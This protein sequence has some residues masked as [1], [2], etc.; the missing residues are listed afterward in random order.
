MKK[1]LVIQQ[2]MIGDVLA[3]SILCN[4]LRKI[5]PKAQIH[6]MVYPFTKPV[7]ENNPNIDKIITY[8]ES[9]KRNKIKQLRFLW[10]VRKE[11][12]NVV[13]DAYN[14][15]ESFLATL[16]SGADLK[17][18]FY[19]KYTK[20]LYHY[21][22]ELLPQP[23][24]NAGTAIENR[25]NLLEPIAPNFAFDNRPKIFITEA[26][27][28]Q[29]LEN[30]KVHGI[31]ES[32]PYLLISVLGSED[33]KSYPATYMAKTLDFIAEELGYK[34]IF[35]FMPKQ[36]A[37]AR[38]I[39]DLCNPATQALIV[40]NLVAKDIRAFLALTNFS[41]A[42][43]GNEGGAVNMAK[44]L[45]KPTFTIF[46]TW[47]KKEAWSSFDNGITHVSVHLKDFKPELYGEKSPK[48]M[49]DKAMEL[50]QAFSPELL[51]PELQRFLVR[52]K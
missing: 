20:F 52:L 14:K 47:I 26:E 7:I 22:V 21:N 48:E 43:I 19:K 28:Q 38:E 4:N 37:Q 42:L 29:A 25:I 50:Y 34:L 46:S 3:S 35:N 30:L 12:Y 36:Q 39:Y 15:P 31:S 9:L 5:Y 49:K 6:Y 8:D 27:K 23:R 17:I 45:Y 41:K 1:I 13:I 51:L 18:G 11:R 16:F 40:S 24:T 33:R 10:Q 32:D 44:A 2:K